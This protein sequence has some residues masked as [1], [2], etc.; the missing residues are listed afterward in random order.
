MKK[1][2]REEATHSAE[3]AHTHTLTQNTPTLLAALAAVT[4][5]T[6]FLQVSNLSGSPTACYIG[7]GCLGSQGAVHTHT[8]K[9]KGQ[10]YHSANEEREEQKGW[11]R[12]W[13]EFGESEKGSLERRQRGMVNKSTSAPKFLQILSHCIPLYILSLCHVASW[14]WVILSITFSMKSTPI[15]ALTHAVKYCIESIVPLCNPWHKHLYVFLVFISNTAGTLWPLPAN[16]HF[17]T[18]LLKKRGTPVRQRRQ[19]RLTQQNGR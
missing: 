5:K 9:R 19:K 14:F 7:V 10:R 4:V 11:G 13:M 3:R 16:I 2:G 17:K 18:L 1:G 8:H 15:K 6:L 12:I